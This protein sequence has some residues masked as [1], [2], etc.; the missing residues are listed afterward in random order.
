ME[1]LPFYNAEMLQ[2]KLEAQE[3]FGKKMF[4]S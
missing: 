2:V 1:I 3:A 4:E